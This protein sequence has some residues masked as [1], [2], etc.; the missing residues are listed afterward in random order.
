MV[1][2]YWQFVIREKNTVIRYNGRRTTDNEQTTPDDAPRTTHHVSRFTLRASRFLLPLGLFLTG[3]GGGF[4][5]WIWRKS[6]ALQLT[7]PGLAEFVKF[8]PE[9]RTG[10]IHIQRLYFLLPLWVAMLL[11]PLVVENRR[12]SLPVWLRWSLRLAIIPLAL[13]S[14]SPVWT[15]AI[16]MASEFR[17]QT[18]LAGLAVGPA[19]IA[20]WLRWLPLKLLVVVLIGGGL[21]ALIL[22]WQHFNLV[23]AG[24][25]AAYSQ[26]V[27]LGWGW[28]LT[29]AGLV[30][31]MGG[32]I[33][34][35]IT[36]K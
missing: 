35:V 36:K 16:L 3:L 18:L 2:S 14:L 30:A 15:P 29:A 11:L 5:P 9:I 31:S 19:I 4:A 20:P 8:L 25:S 10:E 6:V 12:S 22:P 23:Q 7:G 26:P 27:S 28:W 24:I 34:A 21:A 1:I 33:G 32:G 13:A 17:L